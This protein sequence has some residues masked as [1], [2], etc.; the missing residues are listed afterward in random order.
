MKAAESMPSP[1]ST[2]DEDEVK[3]LVPEVSGVLLRAL[4]DVVSQAGISPD[5]LFQHEERQ[6]TAS[7]PTAVRVPLPAYRA[8]FARAI[9]L[10][11]D[12]ALGLRC[13][14]RAREAAFD[15]LGPLVAHTLTLRRAIEEAEQ[16]QALVFDGAHFRLTERGTVA[17]VRCEFPRS[18]DPTDRILAEFLMAGLMR[19][20]RG[21]HC[22]QGDFYTANFEH[23]QPSYHHV[24]RE[25][26]EGKE[27][28]SQEFTGVEFAAH[29]LDRP[30]PYANP[31]LQ[32][33]V[34]AQ[35]EQRLQRLSHPTRFIDRLRMYLLS[36]PAAGVPAMGVAARGLGVSVR[37]MRRRLGESGHT[38]REVTQEM[39]GERARTMLR[40]ADVS[41]QAVAGALGFANTDAF[42]RAFR[43]W[44][45]RTACDYRLGQHTPRPAHQQEDRE[46]SPQRAK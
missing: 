11:G 41:V 30:Q 35:A 25:V 33:L 6:L 29:V 44:T 17:R 7:E 15:L 18:H 22:T 20:L 13:A 9:M 43:R 46:L 12:Q 45:G 3:P 21:L 26:F 2:S 10:T 19:L 37:T 16:F 39:Q 8:L 27:R 28:F 36:Q 1:S 34:H 31:M 4:A 38:Y 40:K 14:L 23:R 5:T 42:H 24:Y 32:R